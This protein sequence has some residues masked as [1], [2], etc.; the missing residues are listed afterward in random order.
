MKKLLL[1]ILLSLLVLNANAAEFFFEKDR[2][3]PLT[4]IVIA[5]RGGSSADP[6]GKN[7]ATDL[8]MR[9]LT[10]GTKTKTKNQI[11]LAVDQL[12]GD[13]AVA[14]QLEY[15]LFQGSVLSKNLKPFL[16]ILTEIL[17][18][19]SFR[20]TEFVKLRAERISELMGSLSEDR[21]LAQ[22][23]FDQRFFR[24]HAYARTPQGRINDL[25]K[26]SVG[27]LESQYQGLVQDTRVLVLATGD[28]SESDFNEFLDRFRTARTMGNSNSLSPLRPIPAF[29]GAPKKLQVVIF[30]KPDRTQTQIVIGQTGINVTDTKRDA[31]TVAN[32]AF[33][34]GIFQSRLMQEL[35]VK[36]GWTYGAGSS[37]KNA[38]LPHSWKVAFFPKNADTAPAI[39]EALKLIRVFGEKG[40]TPEEF[41]FAKQGLINGAGFNFNTPMKRLENKLFEKFYGLPDGTVE[42]LADRLKELDLAIVNQAVKDF[43]KPQQ[44]L[45]GIVG[46][47]STLKA[48][49]A[50]ALK[51]SEGEIEVQDYLKE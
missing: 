39:V 29:S 47:A 2:S 12:G 31:L 45:I 7:G 50:K 14:T 5:I 49:L 24:G 25:R 40:L 37:F 4:R 34:G 35:R 46:T 1:S 23:R 6:D 9:M 38:L 28:A 27:D 19:P 22:V 41:S 20:E 30:D 32:H 8:M 13:L 51:I 33:G 36:R 44:M 18:T 48:D 26:I 42:G 11:D 10:R 43:V 21:S 16:E 15:S 3:L 17:T